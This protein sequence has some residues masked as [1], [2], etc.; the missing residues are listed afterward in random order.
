MKPDHIWPVNECQQV[1]EQIDEI[2]TARVDSSNGDAIAQTIGD[3]IAFYAS[4]SDVVSSLK[5]H[6]ETAYRREF[7]IIAK[8]LKEGNAKAETLP[9]QVPSIL[10]DY[11]KSRTADTQAL[12]VKAE[13]SNA[14]ITHSIEG[15]RSILSKLKEERKINSYQHNV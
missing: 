13:R 1:L 3:L 8:Y 7:E 9:L 15:L 4:S 14:A 2:L 5:W 11:I 6:Q 10:K 12:L